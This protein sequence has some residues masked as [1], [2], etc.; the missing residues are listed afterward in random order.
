MVGAICSF[1]RALSRGNI[2]ARVG[3]DAVEPAA[4]DLFAIGSFR[5]LVPRS[6]RSSD[7]AELG[8]TLA[9]VLLPN[10]TGVRLCMSKPEAGLSM[11]LL[12]LW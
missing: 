5:G 12:V 7:S 1:A 11:L 3:A 10:P 8:A 2:F 6:A 4:H 9:R